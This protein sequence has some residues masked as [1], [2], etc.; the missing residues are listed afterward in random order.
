MKLDVEKFYGNTDQ[1][2]IMILKPGSFRNES[3]ILTI[4]RS[5]LTQHCIHSQLPLQYLKWWR[6]ACNKG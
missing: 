5:Y 4:Y 3:E 2:W 1:I 6:Q